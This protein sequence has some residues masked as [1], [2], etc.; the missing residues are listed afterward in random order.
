MLYAADNASMEL[1]HCGDHDCLLSMTNYML[2]F[3]F[4]YN[5]K[6]WS[7]DHSTALRDYYNGAMKFLSAVGNC[8]QLKKGVAWVL[9][10]RET[11]GFCKKS[12][13]LTIFSQI[14]L[15]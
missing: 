5:W 3:L 13:R 10:G 2:C 15:L 14:L 1:L 7:K 4:V 11:G 6:R 12:T 9:T 8:Q